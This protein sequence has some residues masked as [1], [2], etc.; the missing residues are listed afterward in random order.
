[1]QR[2]KKV[3]GTI[4]LAVVMSLSMAQAFAGPGETPGQNGRGESPDTIEVPKDGPSDDDGGPGETPGG[5]L[6]FEII[7]FL[8]T[9][10]VA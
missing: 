10:L 3:F 9:N 5:R 8:A 7:K 6:M 4:L 1:M 2:L